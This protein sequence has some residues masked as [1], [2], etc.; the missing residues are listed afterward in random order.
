MTAPIVTEPPDPEDPETELRNLRHRNQV[1]EAAANQYA[2]DRWRMF[3][4]HLNFRNQI[5]DTSARIDTQMK[6]QQEQIED[7]SEQLRDLQIR[8]SE[9][10]DLLQQ[11]RPNLVRALEL[12]DAK[13][14]EYNELK[15]QYDQLYAQHESLLASLG[16]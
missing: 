12:Y 2:V 6:K 10:L 8:Y 7:L 9:T 5:A 16:V 14:R 13:E 15:V 4:H 3:F 11:M 1:L